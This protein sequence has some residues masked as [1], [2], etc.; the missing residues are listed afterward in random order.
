MHKERVSVCAGV[1]QV[2]E[3]RPEE[4]V[5]VDRASVDTYVFVVFEVFVAVRGINYDELFVALGK[6]RIQE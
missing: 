1:P 6:K 3:L 5:H 4:F 2:Y